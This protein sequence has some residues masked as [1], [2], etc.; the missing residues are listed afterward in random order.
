MSKINR[1]RIMNLNYNNNTIRID[2]ETFDMGGETTLLS[3]RNGGGKTVLVQMVTSL[4]VNKAY[5]DFEERP[6]KSYFTTNKP[7]FIMVE[8]LLDHGQ[9]YFLTGMMVRKCQNPEENGNEELEMLNF[10]GSYKSP[11][12]YDLDN[13]PVIEISGDRRALKGFGA[14]RKEFENLKKNRDSDFAY[15]DMSGQYQRRQYFS[16][17]KEYQIDNKEWESII[18]KVNLKESG[19]SELFNNAKDEKG[20]IEKW[21]LHAVKNKLNQEHD[22]IKEFQSLAYKFIERYRSNQENIRRKEIIEK[23]FDDAGLMEQQVEKFIEASEKFDYQKSCIADFIKGVDIQLTAISEQINNKRAEIEKLEDQIINIEG[24]KISYNIYKLQDERDEVLSKRVDIEKEVTEARITKEKKKK[25]LCRYNCARLYEEVM[26]FERKIKQLR[27]KIDILTKEQEDGALE[28]EKL[29]ATLYAYYADMVQRQEKELEECETRLQKINLS[30]EDTEKKINDKNNEVR[31]ISTQLGELNSS[32]KNFDVDENRFNLRYGTDFQRNI[33]GEYEEGILEIEKSKFDEEAVNISLDI[34]KTANKALACK[35]ESEKAVSDSEEAKVN[36]ERKKSEYAEFE[37]KYNEYNDEKNRRRVIMK[38]IDAP[39][40]ELDNKVLIL[41]RLNRKLEE[42]EITRDGFKLQLQE[43]RKEYENLRQGKIIELPEN[44]TQFLESLNIQIIYGMV[45]LKKNGRT[46]E[47]NKKLVKNNPFLPFSV[48]MDSADIEKIGG[49]QGEIYTS[50]PIPIVNR[51]DIEKAV[52][53]SEDCLI[54]FDNISFMVSFNLKLLEQESLEKMLEQKK[55][56]IEDCEKKIAI[57]D[58]E[59]GSYREYRMT[60][61]QQSFSSALI[62]QLEMDMELALKETEALQEKYIECQ[63]R[64]K[65]SAEEYEKLQHKSVELQRKQKDIDLRNK[66]YIDYIESYESYISDR[67]RREHLERKRKDTD[68]ILKSLE[69]ER[70]SLLRQG[71]QQNN[72]RNICQNKRN[73]LRKEVSRYEQYESCEPQE[74]DEDTDFVA[75]E[76]RYKALTNNIAASLEELNQD[77]QQES[78][79]HEKKLIQLKSANKYDFEDRELGTVVYSEEIVIQLEKEM[80]AC[81]KREDTAVKQSGEC[82]RQAESLKKDIEFEFNKLYEKT[83]RKELTDQKLIVDTDF[84]KRL[85]VTKYDKEK[86]EKSV[87]ELNERKQAFENADSAMAEYR[88]YEITCNVP[89]VNF[90]DMGKEEITQYHGTLRK[91]LRTS[92]NECGSRMQET[93]ELIREI[94]SK[95]QYQED[96]FKKSFDNLIQVSHDAGII[97]TQ[98]ATLT[99]SYHTMLKKLE[100]DLENVDKERKNVEELFIEYVRDVHENIG[101]I[102]RNSSINVRGRSRKMLEISMPDWIENAD[103]YNIRLR[104]YIDNIVRRGIETIEENK[105]VEEIL[106]KLITT[107]KMYDDIVGI[108]NIGIKMYK[109]EAER[110]LPISWAQV[111]ANSGG[112]GFLSAF[113]IL[114][115]LLS[116]MRRDSSDIFATG[117]EGKVLVMDNPFA[118]TNAVH[119][120]KPL[121]DMAKKT[122]TQLICLSGLGGDSIYNRFDNIYVINLV[123]SNM[124]KGMQYMNTQH[125]KGEN[126]KKL[127]LSEF[128][129]EQLTL[130]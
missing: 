112:E 93:Y 111:S 11:C 117:E 44:I 76:E 63:Q 75:I 114:T 102:D 118:Q 61:E 105:N 130:F 57:K 123:S 32:I 84:E 13:I 85:R 74:F 92:D 42:L 99:E 15:Y 103:Y 126:I 18:K 52:S 120:L 33:I 88:D 43:L 122:N 87:Y 104:D 82:E 125:L 64:K 36:I 60:I 9:G 17:L 4:F 8:W 7:T 19:L 77:L 26:D 127:E 89:V 128:K 95:P 30:I 116:Y 124:R 3:L 25:E 58:D 51:E 5:R 35:Q 40:S 21:F 69:A 20:L 96:F 90:D 100:V 54:K 45:W 27:E 39:E 48:I 83:G 119:L 78:G 16:K 12:E 121:M 68:N 28:V 109:I 107:E 97:R 71:D 72:I 62:L 14:C 113:I 34:T 41:D 98:L 115:C 1:L 56:D 2:D 86:I 81:G 22:R 38:Y 94:A 37:R 46:V 6:F 53:E 24:E 67:A 59:I 55:K 29:G 23:Y 50:F 101:Q 80:E 129:L 31:D 108:E 49:K 10:T 47:Q 73:E 110:E 106:G 65:E 91:N 66:E 70:S 79:R